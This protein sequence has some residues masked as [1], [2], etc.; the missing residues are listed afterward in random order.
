MIAVR[1]FR[2]SDGTACGQ[3]FFRA[4]RE[5]AAGFYDQAQR[6]D[7]A[8]EGVDAPDMAK[9]LSA[10]SAWVSEER[11]RITGFMSLTADG[12]L[13][14][15][16]VLPEAMGKGHAAPIYDALLAHAR[17]AGLPRLTVHASEY[18]RRFL[19][20]RGWRLDRVELLARPSGITFDRNH[21]SLTLTPR[22]AA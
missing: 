12:H 20:R 10:Q 21:M 14:L 3:V 22:A 17:A 7:W 16:F 18:A 15:A 11:G 13:D 9:K 5:G 2:P 19:D 6:L 1:P 4:V 8:P